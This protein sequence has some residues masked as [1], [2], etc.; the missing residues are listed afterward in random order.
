M[1]PSA[2]TAAAAAAAAA[3]AAAPAPWQ[4][5][6]RCAGRCGPRNSRQPRG[7]WPSRQ[8]DASRKHHGCSSGRGGLRQLRLAVAVVSCGFCARPAG[9]CDAAPSLAVLN[10]SLS[11]KGGACCG[12]EQRQ[13]APAEQIYSWLCCTQ[14]NWRRSRCSMSSMRLSGG[15]PRRAA[16]QRWLTA[17]PTGRQ[18]CHR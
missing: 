16:L 15:R 4:F 9:M 3:T 14:A 7:R 10:G 2:A 1:P 6:G 18:P 11:S 13:L 8:P 5:D 12:T 17:A